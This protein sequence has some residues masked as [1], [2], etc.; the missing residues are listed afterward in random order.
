[1]SSPFVL[2]VIGKLAPGRGSK[3]MKIM[4]RL[5][6]ESSPAPSPKSCPSGP[7]FSLFF[8]TRSLKQTNACPLRMNECLLKFYCLFVWI[9]YFG[10]KQSRIFSLSAL[11]KVITVF[12]TDAT[13]LFQS[14]LAPMQ[15]KFAGKG[16]Q[17]LVIPCGHDFSQYRK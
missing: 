5:L 8:W 17:H 11:M 14:G 6:R 3:I 4:G 7:E 13:T 1:M 9:R 15:C 2:F 16:K 10:L 12:F